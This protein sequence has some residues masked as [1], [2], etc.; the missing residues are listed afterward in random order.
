M[1][2]H[3]PRVLVHVAAARSLPV[4]FPAAVPQSRFHS[5]QSRSIPRAAVVVIVHGPQM[6]DAT[7]LTPRQLSQGGRLRLVNG[8]SFCGHCLEPSKAS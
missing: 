5:L 4:S 7:V 3:G 6:R 8:F 2:E 1:D